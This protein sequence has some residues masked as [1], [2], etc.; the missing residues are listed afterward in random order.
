MENRVDRMN[1]KREHCLL[2]KY[3]FFFW[4]FD[5]CCFA[6]MCHDS[7]STMSIPYRRPSLDTFQWW[8]GCGHWAINKDKGSWVQ[9]RTG[10][11]QKSI[12]VD[13]EYI[14]IYIYIC[15]YVNIYMYIYIYTCIYIYIYIIFTYIYIYHIYV[16]IYIYY[17]YI[18]IY[19]TI[20]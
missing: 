14:C 4:I 13:S 7:L 1:H 6:N 19:Y 5:E 17:I 3:I 16:Y 9:G 11:P 20:L 2:K 10:F 8:E 12:G 15:M 18:Y